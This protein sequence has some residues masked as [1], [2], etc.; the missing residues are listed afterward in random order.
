MPG[1]MQL[2]DAFGGPRG[3]AATTGISAVFLHEL[4]S[5]GGKGRG[6][7][8]ATQDGRAFFVEYAAGI[9]RRS[10]LT[11]AFIFI[12]KAGSEKEIWRI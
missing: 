11:P 1:Y 3:T 4:F 10:N 5:S 6:V 9:A 8:H 2:P 7:L 12:K